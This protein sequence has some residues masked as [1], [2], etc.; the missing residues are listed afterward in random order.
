MAE[1]HSVTLAPHCPLGPIA[2]AASF[3]STSPHPTPSWETS[4]GIHYNAG[5]GLLDYLVDTSVFDF[6]DSH[7]ARPTAPPA[8][9]SRST[10]PPYARL[11]RK[12]SGGA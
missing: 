8:W 11:R 3:R 7:I 9:A 6:T 4:L 10:K 12:V 1:A 2:F 5:H